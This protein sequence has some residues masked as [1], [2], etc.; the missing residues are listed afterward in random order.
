MSCLNRV[1]NKDDGEKMWNEN[2]MREFE[3][4]K[5]TLEMFAAFK[6][7]SNQNKQIRERNDRKKLRYIHLISVDQNISK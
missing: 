5:M 7:K 2:F 4:Q 1:Q 6:I 3:E